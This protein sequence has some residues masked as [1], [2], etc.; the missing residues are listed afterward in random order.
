[1]GAVIKRGK[2]GTLSPI[3]AKEQDAARALP[4]EDVV[5]IVI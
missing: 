1:M 3:N 2:K 4:I 5:S